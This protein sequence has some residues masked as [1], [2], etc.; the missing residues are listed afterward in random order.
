MVC[1]LRKILTLTVPNLKMLFQKKRSSGSTLVTQKNWF[2]QKKDFST[3]QGT[4]KYDFAGLNDR[5][6]LWKHTLQKHAQSLVS[7]TRAFLTTAPFFISRTF[8]VMVLGSSGAVLSLL[9]YFKWPLAVGRGADWQLQCYP[10]F[11]P[12]LWILLHCARPA[13]SQ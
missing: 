7:F 2:I 3:L 8:L 4:E 12:F 10:S 6:L 1:S 9:S 13:V 5:S 11:S